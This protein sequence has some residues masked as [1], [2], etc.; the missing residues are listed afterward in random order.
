LR[1]GDDLLVKHVILNNRSIDID[2]Y[3]ETAVNGLTKIS[4][5]FKVNHEDYHEITTL[6]YNGTFDVEVPEKDLTFKGTIDNYS[7]SIINLYKQGNVGDFQ[8][9]LLEVG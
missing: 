4:I 6:L 2:G 1:K 5:H 9:S 3:E 8:L 7:T